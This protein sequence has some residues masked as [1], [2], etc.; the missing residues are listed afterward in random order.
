MVHIVHIWTASRLLAASTAHGISHD[1]KGS[2]L[3]MLETSEQEQSFALEVKLAPSDEND[4]G[5]STTSFVI[6]TLYAAVVFFAGPF[7]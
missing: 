7:I 5:L 2:S 4:S 3:R 6:S 1:V